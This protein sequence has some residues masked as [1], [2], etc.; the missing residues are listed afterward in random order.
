[1]WIKLV[2]TKEA[3]L[4]EFR[5]GHKHTQFI[6]SVVLSVGGITALKQNIYSKKAFVPLHGSRKGK[7]FATTRI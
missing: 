3:T 7:I 4:V 6:T 1:M 5:S 2:E